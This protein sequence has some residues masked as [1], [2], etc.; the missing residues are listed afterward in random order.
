MCLG[1]GLELEIGP[2][3]CLLCLWFC[4]CYVF[5]PSSLCCLCILWHTLAPERGRTRGATAQLGARIRSHCLSICLRPTL[6]VT[7][8]QQQ[9]GAP[10]R[11]R[12]AG[13]ESVQQRR[14]VPAARR[15]HQNVFGTRKQPG[16]ESN[17]RR[18]PS[19]SAAGRFGCVS[20]VISEQ[21]FACARGRTGPEREG[22][23]QLC[24]GPLGEQRRARRCGRGGRPSG[25]CEYAPGRPPCRGGPRN[26]W[27]QRERLFW[28]SANVDWPRG[29]SFISV[30]FVGGWHEFSLTSFAVQMR[31][32]RDSL[33]LLVHGLCGAL[34]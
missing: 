3:N 30:E 2:A 19:L 17:D 29:R 10:L 6:F 9:E 20:A 28:C 7:R 21:V 11:G 5:S 1:G 31:P 33:T 8:G 23:R 15:Q 12:R 22:R 13:R 4:Y 26:S 24:L 18:P 14:L 34:A 16:L 25:G 32:E 27:P